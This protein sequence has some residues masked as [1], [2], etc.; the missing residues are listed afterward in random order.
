MT[1]DMWPKPEITASADQT[2]VEEDA[3][4]Q[5]EATGALSYRW[6]PVL[7]LNDPN[8]ANP[9]ATVTETTLFTVRGQSADGCSDTTTVLI[10]V[11]QDNAIKVEPRNLFSP[12]GD[13][14]D[15]Y[16][17]IENIERYPGSNV[18]IYNGMGSIVYESNNYNN[19][20]DAV[21]NGKNLPETAYF[22]VIKYEDKNP[23]T[24]SVTIIR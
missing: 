11:I 8:I 2:D 6:S 19:D 4:V 10:T 13:G 24:G 1:I 18:T 7:L 14:I 16:W 17:V 22:F 20:W 15:D 3:E 21:Y 9:I 23:K 5:L 12:N